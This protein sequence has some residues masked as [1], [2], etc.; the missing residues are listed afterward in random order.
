M[1]AQAPTPLSREPGQFQFST[2]SESITG[3]PRVCGGE[4]SWQGTR[5]GSSPALPGGSHC[6]SYL[7]SYPLSIGF[8]ALLK[9]RKLAPLST[10]QT[11]CSSCLKSSIATEKL[12]PISFSILL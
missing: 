4:A 5:P 8:L 11:L 2:L 12:M 10:L 7:M 9:F 3:S 1:F 6:F